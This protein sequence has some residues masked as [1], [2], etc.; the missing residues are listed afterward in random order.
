[1][2]NWNRLWN[3]LGVERGSAAKRSRPNG[4][5]AGCRK[6]RVSSPEARRPG[7]DFFAP[8]RVLRL[9]R[10]LFFGWEALARRWLVVT[11]DRAVRG[12]DLPVGETES[13]LGS[14]DPLVGDADSSLGYTN[15][16]V[17]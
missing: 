6:P 7:A 10:V 8:F 13:S 2:R 14:H 17:D 1:M 15:S 4:G 16:A 5:F 9:R 12:S 11:T 3:A